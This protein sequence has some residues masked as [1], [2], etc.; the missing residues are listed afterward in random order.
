[1]ILLE[2]LR[3]LFRNL[4]CLI[5]T[6]LDATKLTKENPSHRI[7]LFSSLDEHSLL[8]LRRIQLHLDGVSTFQN[9]WNT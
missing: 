8:K 6:F 3:R 7:L 5:R 4:A 1:M 9:R 2:F